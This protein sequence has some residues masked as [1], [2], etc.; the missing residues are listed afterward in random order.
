SG[1]MSTP[2]RTPVRLSPFLLFVWA[3]VI[4]GLLVLL[5]E[6]SVILP[7]LRSAALWLYARG[8]ALNAAVSGP[9]NRLRRTSGIPLLA[10]LLLGLM[11]ATAPCQLSTGAAAL[12]YVSRDARSPLGSA[13]AYLGARLLFYV[14]VGA[15]VMYILIG[16]VQAPGAF[17]LGVRRVLGPLTLGIGLVILGVLRPRFELGRRLSER[18]ESYA[19]NLK[20]HVG[21]FA[22]GLAFSFAFC[23]TLFFLF[24]GLTLPL[25][26]NAPFGWGY[27]A[28]FALGMTLPLLVFASL[29]P[30]EDSAGQG[31]YLSSVRTWRRMATPL[32]GTVFLM[33]GAYDTFVYWL[34]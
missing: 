3:G 4:L 32:A 21:A 7:H 10:P 5:F 1:P 26:L 30:S 13:G 8:N 2:A 14:L 33:A 28:L 34:L 20:G 18:A 15:F 9:L 25:A 31:R 27:P 17:F 19:R 16:Q 12:A 22:L 6:W 11:A 29:I 24:F 23:P